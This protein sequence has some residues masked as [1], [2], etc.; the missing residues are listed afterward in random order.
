MESSWFV[1]PCDTGARPT[2]HSSTWSLWWCH[3]PSKVRKC[4]LIQTTLKTSP[5]TKEPPPLILF[6]SDQG[7]SSFPHAKAS[8][9]TEI[10]FL[11]NRRSERLMDQSA[12]HYICCRGLIPHFQHAKEM[13]W[14]R[15]FSRVGKLSPF[16]DFRG[17]LL[18][19]SLHQGEEPFIDLE[20]TARPQIT[21]KF[22]NICSSN[23]CYVNPES[24]WGTIPLCRS[25]KGK[26]TLC[27]SPARDK[28]GYWKRIFNVPACFLQAAPR[29]FPDVE[30]TAFADMY[31]SLFYKQ[32]LLWNNKIAKT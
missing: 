4:Q 17:D 7:S 8:N 14:E 16:P 26:A 9:S 28:S 20:E 3:S 22:Q 23:D 29:I 5:N 19:V 15:W 12:S 25:G 21:W 1:L 2:L 10:Q 31:K 30:K 24:C 32:Q 27:L 13:I 11:W 18:S 6:T